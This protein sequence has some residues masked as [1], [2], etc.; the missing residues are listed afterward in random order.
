MFSEINPMAETK[1]GIG[2][3]HSLFHRRLEK[4]DLANLSFPPL[5]PLNPLQPVQK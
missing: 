4:T 5:H 2:F 3:L 1:E